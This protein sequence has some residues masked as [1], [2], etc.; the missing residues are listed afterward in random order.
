M[1]LYDEYNWGDAFMCVIFFIGLFV[2]FGGVYLIG[3]KEEQ[4]KHG[5]R[6]KLLDDS[7]SIEVSIA[8][9]TEGSLDQNEADGMRAQRYSRP[10]F[11]QNLM[12]IS[13]CIC[14]LQFIQGISRIYGVKRE[15]GIH[16][17]ILSCSSQARRDT[18]KSGWQGNC[19]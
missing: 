13:S 2:T 1:I 12:S 4:C 8:E 19:Q 17:R 14:L 10:A 18:G 11:P 15:H 16:E 6:E 3:K 7:Q 5:S 9:Y